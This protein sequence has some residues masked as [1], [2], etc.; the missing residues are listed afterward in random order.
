MIII[1]F[2]TFFC[3]NPAPLLEN[4]SK[5]LDFIGTFRPVI[6]CTM[7]WHPPLGNCGFGPIYPIFMESEQITHSLSAGFM[8]LH[9]FPIPVAYFCIYIN[10][11]LQKQKGP[12]KP[13]LCFLIFQ[14]GSAG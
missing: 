8:Q 3:K 13:V 2:C 1:A 12:D 14:K 6:L 5:Y 4:S 10:L 9:P 7:L 11:I